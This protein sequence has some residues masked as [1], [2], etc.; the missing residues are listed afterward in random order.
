MATVQALEQKSQV[1]EAR[2]QI[3]HSIAASLLLH[4]GPAYCS[5]TAGNEQ[6]WFPVCFH[7][8]PSELQRRVG[9]GP[10]SSKVREAGFRVRLE[11]E[12]ICPAMHPKP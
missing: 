6:L 2:V 8:S 3:W 7:S 9:C 12:P 11:M 4:S 10:S 1:C 5:F